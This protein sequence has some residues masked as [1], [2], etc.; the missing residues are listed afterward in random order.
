MTREQKIS[1]AL[2]RVLR[3]VEALG[4]IDSVAKLTYFEM[5]VTKSSEALARW[6]ELHDARMEA[7]SALAD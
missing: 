3:A 1:K 7:M 2:R 6:N 4:Q 5:N